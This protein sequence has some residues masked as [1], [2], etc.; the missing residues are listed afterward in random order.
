MK[1]MD[2]FLKENLLP[3]CVPEKSLNASIVKKV[4]GTQNMKHRTWK[5]S[6]AAAI[7]ILV[8]G[9]ASAYAAYRYLTPSQVAEQITEDGALAKAFESKDAIMVNETQKTA[10]YDITL[11]G[12]VSGK[13][14]SSVTSE[15]VD[16]TKTY[17][18]AAIAREDGKAMPDTT[19][20]NY[21]TFCVSAL[22]HGERFQNVNNAALN[23]GVTSFV[24]D[25][26]QYELLECD[27]LEMFA[28]KGV[29]M[30]I[31]E[32]F[33][34]ESQAFVMNKKT[35]DYAVNKDFDGMKALFTIPLDKSK[36]DDAAAEQYF[37]KI[38]EKENA[39][40]AEKENNENK[41]AAN[42]GS[43]SEES[44]LT[45]E[46]EQ[47]LMKF[48]TLTSKKA[49]AYVKKHAEVVVQETCNAG[50]DGS[51]HVK[52]DA[53]ESDYNVSAY[54]KVG[55]ENVISFSS[56]GT[57]AGTYGETITPNEDG[58]YTYTVYRPVNAE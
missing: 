12:I 17:A 28:N 6:V 20:D 21:Q 31:V 55:V 19:D 50:A 37:E 27:N 38:G 5:L 29:Y 22:V 33:G 3:D 18:V 39:K 16:Q 47:K 56:D 48:R 44:R 51:I 13:N 41:A 32:S 34:N 7:A 53:G 23:A 2:E 42:A 54:T 9:S 45:S 57:F 25:G 43:K 26:V 4:K 1:E 58:T 35:G 36:A 30:G 15:A 40:T 8:V 11:M 14:L 49:Q 24:Q 46:W 10:G 52:S